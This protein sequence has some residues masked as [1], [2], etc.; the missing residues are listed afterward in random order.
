MEQFIANTVVTTK[1]RCKKLWNDLTFR[2]MSGALGDLGTFLPLIVALTKAMQLDLGT[3]LL[4]T[5]VYNI[6]TGVLFDIPM[7]VSSLIIPNSILL[8]AGAN[9][10]TVEEKIIINS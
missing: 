2:E 6:V 10:K 8:A 3:T 5:G 7:P 1:Q 9:L 4:F